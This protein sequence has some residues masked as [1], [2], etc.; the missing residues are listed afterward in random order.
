MGCGTSAP[1]PS[2]A[3][4]STDPNDYFDYSGNQ[5]WY[6]CKPDVALQPRCAKSGFA[7]F[8]KCPPT[9][10]P[11]LLKMAAQKAGSLP[12]LKV[13]RPCPPAD[14]KDVPPALPDNEWKTWTW[15]EYYDDAR[16]VGKGF[17]KL[18]LQQFDSVA[19]W[20]FNSPEWML[21]TIAAGM[22]GAKSAGLYPTD[23]PETAA[24]KVVHSGASIVVIEDKTKLDRLLPALAERSTTGNVKAFVAYG[25][26]PAEGETAIVRNAAVPVISWSALVEMGAKSELDGELDARNK[27]VEPGHCAALVYTSGTTGEPKAWVC[28]QTNLVC[29][30]AVSTHFSA[31][32]TPKAPRN[33]L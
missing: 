31:L 4:V 27:A 26:E 24:F 2:A 18:G 13:E 16:N 3:P 6:T 7:S 5:V 14:G 29:G 20:G 25:Y 33:W 28:Y 8:E 22:A 15:Q 10:L 23:A 21:T 11:A 12:A 17:L 19:I 30:E 32:Q 9:T 1:A